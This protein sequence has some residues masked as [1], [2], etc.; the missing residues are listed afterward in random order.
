VNL[1]DL[2]PYF[3]RREH[4]V[5]IPVESIDHADGV[6]FLCPKCFAANA[7]SVGTHSIICWRPRVPSEV[8]PKPGRWEFSGTGLADLSLVAGSSSV[9]LQGG[10]NAHFFVEAG[11]IRM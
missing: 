11:K 3:I 8:D 5:Y 7:G 9:L 1:I 6:L 2:E 10:C 4:E